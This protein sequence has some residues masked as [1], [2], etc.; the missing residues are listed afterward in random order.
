MRDHWSKLRKSSATIAITFFDP[1]RKEILQSVL[2][3][4]ILL[5]WS[6]KDPID[7]ASEGRISKIGFLN[8]KVAEKGIFQNFSDHVES[9]EP[10]NRLWVDGIPPVGF[11]HQK[12]P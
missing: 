7:R 8:T 9:K 11:R 12:L 5:Q 1:H 4:G 10:K 2:T 3:C 6:Q